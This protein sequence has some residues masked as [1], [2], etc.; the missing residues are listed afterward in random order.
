MNRTKH[1][2]AKLAILAA[3][4]VGAI[5]AT[6]HAAIDYS[7]DLDPSNPN[8]WT[9]STTAY[10]GKTGTGSVSVADGS[11]LLSGCGYIGYNSGSTGEVTVSSEGSTWTNSQLH[12]GY[13]GDGT[14]NI[15]DGATV[16]NSFCHI[17]YYFNS[18][19]EVTVSGNGSTWTNGY[20]QVGNYGTG[21]LNITDGGL[22]NV[23]GITYVD[24]EGNATGSINFGTGGGI[25]TTRSLVT[26]FSRLFGTG[27]IN[28]NGIVGDYDLVFDSTHGLAQTFTIGGSGQ[29][30]N[31]T[32]TLDMNDSGSVGCLG[33]N[34]GSLTINGIAVNSRDGYIGYYPGSTGT[35]TISGEDATWTNNGLYVGT[36]GDGTLNITNGGLVSV[37]NT[38][39][40]AYY[41]GATGSIHFGTGG[42]TLTTRSLVASSA[43]LFGTGTINTN[44]IVSDYD[45]VFDSTHGLT[46]TFTI[47]GSEQDR[48]I[49]VNLDMS[50]PVE[51]LGVNDG[52]LT[53][54]GIAV[55]SQD[56]HI[57]YYSGSTGEVTV[58]GENSSWTNSGSLY[59]GNYGNGTLDITGGASVS[60]LFGTIGNNSGSTGEVTVSGE[61]STWTNSGLEI[62][63][64]GTGTLNITNGGTV[65]CATSHIGCYSNPT[66]EVTVSGEGSTWTN[67]GYLYV[68]H[69]GTGTS[70]LNITDGGT[71]SCAVSYIGYNSRMT[72]EVTV[73]GEG[74]TWINNSY[75]Q[76]GDYGAGTLNITD[77]GLV[78]VAG[79]LTIDYDLDDDSF[80]NMSDSGMLALLGDADDSLD[81]FLDLIGGTDAIQWWDP[82]VADW[83]LL[84]TATMGT[85]YTLEYIDDGS[86]LD[87]YTLLTVTAPKQIPGDANRDGQ[88]D[89]SD[90]TILAG[91]WQASG[92]SWSMGDFNGDGTVNASD[93]TILAGNW[94]FGTGAAVPEPGTITLLLTALIGLA[95]WVRRWNFFA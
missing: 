74:S 18:I 51:Y 86:E 7:G 68:G 47:G 55:S 11:D 2:W 89:A 57:G 42:G 80:L 88:V 23:T 25:L 22:V 38:T 49:T 66:G 85:D 6:T 34:H 45:L 61:G 16:S 76:V 64:S 82:A 39:Y 10:I 30:R 50:S 9:S 72:G 40:V 62:G 90:A 31:I 20:L 4:A 41:E 79:N 28:A 54:N 5:P 37:A 36:S 53:I 59:V 32:V 43:Q 75:L 83:N 13:S 44:S 94:Q 65:S 26:S 29:A 69:S 8:T 12:I 35:V 60:N 93:A 71:V 81:D 24:Y 63:Y 77:G 21:T 91:N 46:R 67:S 14:L 70:T 92:A 48:N 19:G 1:F 17:G 3:F 84:T 56:G 52:S 58:S 87:G 95:V 15:T 27:T 33:V 78:R 73:S